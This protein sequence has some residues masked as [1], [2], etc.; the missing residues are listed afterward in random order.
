MAQA[1]DRRAL[2]ADVATANGWDEDWLNDAVQ[3]HL[4]PLADRAT[5][6][7]EF[8]SVP[9]AGEPRLRVHVPTAPYMLALKLKAIGRVNHPVRGPQETAD[10]RNLIRA[11]GVTDVDGAIAIFARCFPR[12]AQDAEK[13][14]FLL[15]HI[16]P[17]TTDDDPPRYPV[18]GR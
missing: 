6:H 5:D 11:A 7:V 9:S 14:R 8:G 12:S 10:I 13:Q 17:D 1:F 3:V 18:P 2:V 15:R 4:S 16:W